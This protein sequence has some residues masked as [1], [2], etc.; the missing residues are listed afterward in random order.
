MDQLLMKPKIQSFA[1]SL[2][3]W[4]FLMMMTDGSGGNGVVV[5]EQ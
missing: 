4:G 2:R 3:S 1:L 5:N